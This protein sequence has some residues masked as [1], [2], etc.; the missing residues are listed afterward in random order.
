MIAEPR[1]ICIRFGKPSL[2]NDHAENVDV[3]ATV[4]HEHM[5]VHPALGKTIPRLE[6][7]TV[8]HIPTGL[9]MC[10]APKKPVAVAAAAAFARLPIDWGFTDPGVP[11]S[12]SEELRSKLRSLKDMAT[13]GDINSLKGACR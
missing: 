1:I 6:R 7:W 5:A 12:W 4:V 9:A 2:G 11:S 10:A 13:L 8:T 3:H